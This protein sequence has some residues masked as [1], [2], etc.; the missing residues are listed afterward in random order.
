[1]QQKVE[2]RSGTAQNKNEFRYDINALRAIAIIGVIFFH[3][4]IRGF[5]GGFSGVDIFLWYPVT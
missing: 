5:T 1:M 2:F 4:K 3:Y